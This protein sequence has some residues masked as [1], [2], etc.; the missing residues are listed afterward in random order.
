MLLISLA[1]S[2]IDPTTSSFYIFKT[3]HPNCTAT[4]LK[5]S[6]QNASGGLSWAT[7]PPKEFSV[8]SPTSTNAWAVLTNDGTASGTF[9]AIAKV[10]Y[11][12]LCP[13]GIGSLVYDWQMTVQYEDSNFV[14][15]NVNIS[16][17]SETDTQWGFT[18]GYIFYVCD[19]YKGYSCDPLMCSG[20]QN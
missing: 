5:S 12:I 3:M 8:P 2:Q 7:T 4:L 14:S 1:V 10:A 18:N 19:C 13:C 11:Q 6:L 20:I 15:R 16:V 17:T 9:K